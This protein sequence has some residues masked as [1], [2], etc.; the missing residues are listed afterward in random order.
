MAARASRCAVSRL[1]HPIP[2]IP[3]GDFELEIVTGLSLIT[4]YIFHGMF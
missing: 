1:S 2:E 3:I 4:G